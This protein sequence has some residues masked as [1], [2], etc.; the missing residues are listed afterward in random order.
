[1][2][3]SRK[4]K[5]ISAQ[6]TQKIRPEKIHTDELIP[7]VKSVLFRS[8]DNEFGTFL[9]L[10]WTNSTG[11][12]MDKYSYSLPGF[13]AKRLNYFQELYEKTGDLMNERTV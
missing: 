4:I 2:G 9:Q 1:M 7:K 3:F 8:F 12:C 13:D 5:V 10:P 6:N 11:F